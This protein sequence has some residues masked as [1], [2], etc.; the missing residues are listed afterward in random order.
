MCCPYDIDINLRKI[1]IYG[2]DNFNCS[3]DVNSEISPLLVFFWKM[4]GRPS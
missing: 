4:E 2:Q 1:F 3:R